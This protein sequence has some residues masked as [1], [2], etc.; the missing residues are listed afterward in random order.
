MGDIN[1]SIAFLPDLGRLKRQAAFFFDL[2]PLI[3]AAARNRLSP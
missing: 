2:A 1:S 3:R